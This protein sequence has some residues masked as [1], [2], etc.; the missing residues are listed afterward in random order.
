MHPRYQRVSCYG[1]ILLLSGLLTLGA[2]RQKIADQPRQNPLSPSPFFDDG[3]SARPR[4]PGTVARG[5]LANDALQVPAT[6]TE[7]PIPVTPALLARGRERFN[8]YCSVCHGLL[9]NGDG[10]IPRRGFRHPPSY[11]TERLRKAPV[12]HFYDV[13]TNGIGVMPRY[14]P[15]V[16]PRD[17]WAI[18][19]YV[20]A[21]QLSQYARV[22]A[23]PSA[24]RQHLEEGGA[25]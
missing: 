24:D 8:I 25:R 22:S 15:Q 16:P 20:R 18:I 17:R 10:M 4:V 1:S 21:L 6:A 9:G 2:C 7:F 5:E 19:A 12:G 3:R 23:L 11:H 14:G 13:I